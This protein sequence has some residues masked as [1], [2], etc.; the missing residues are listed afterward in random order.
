MTSLRIITQSMKRTHSFAA[1]LKLFFDPQ[2][3][4]TLVKEVDIPT[5]QKKSDQKVILETLSC[6]NTAH[7]KPD[8]TPTAYVKSRR[9]RP[10]QPRITTTS[11]YLKENTKAWLEKDGESKE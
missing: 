3:K 4:Q 6:P 7:L 9:A 2:V 11:S 5:K 10:A 1:L 8:I